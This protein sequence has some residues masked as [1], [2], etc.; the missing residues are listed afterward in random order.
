M[1]SEAHTILS[2]GRLSELLQKAINESP[3]PIEGDFDQYSSHAVI[4]F[5]MG[6]RPDAIAQ[7][8]VG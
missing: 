5:Y 3:K 1:A 6:D 8:K 7:I 4:S 2:I